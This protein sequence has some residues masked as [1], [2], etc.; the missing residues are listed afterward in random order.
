MKKLLNKKI[1]IGITIS[2]AIFVL[3][4]TAVLAYFLALHRFNL[5]LNN[6]TDKQKIYKKISM[7]DEKIRANFYKPIDED[8]V[9]D[10]MV[11][12]YIN[13]LDDPEA[14]Y[15]PKSEYAK[16]KL[17]SQKA[18]LENEN[19]VYAE[20]RDGKIGYIY[21]SDFAKDTNVHLANVLNEYLNTDINKIVLDLRNNSGENIESAAQSLKLFVPNNVDLIKK[22][23]NNNQK[24]VLYTSDNNSVDKN[25]V[26]L[27]NG[28]TSNAAELF[29]SA[30]RDNLNI[31]LIGEKTAG[32]AT[33]TN[34]FS[35]YDGSGFEI[36][37]AQYLTTKE[38]PITGI[39]LQPDV[40]VTLT[41]DE[42]DKLL[43]LELPASEDEQYNA[44]VK[45]S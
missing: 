32:K 5:K 1:S 7:T 42:N 29:A 31:K 20:Y 44:A 25:I 40:S 43:K 19:D 26:I 21:I 22:V 9:A 37:T 13:A 45:Q 12:G 41:E 6:L 34:F 36:S 33:E 4:I 14:K 16:A 18:N 27:I 17:N 15:L 2:I 8:K 39:G 28:N 24:T 10:G 3:C 35:L 38:K 11:E 23:D 30:M